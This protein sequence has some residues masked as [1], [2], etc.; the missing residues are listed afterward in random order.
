MSIIF[1][2]G[3]G[4]RRDGLCRIGCPNFP[5]DFCTDNRPEESHC[6]TRTPMD[7]PQERELADP[8]ITTLLVRGRW[9]TRGLCSVAFRR[10]PACVTGEEPVELWRFYIAQPWR[11]RR[12]ACTHAKD[13]KGCLSARQ[14]HVMAWSVGAQRASEGLLSQDGFMDV[15]SHVF[16][17]GTDA[18]TDRILV[19]PL[20]R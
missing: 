10:A 11:A 15:G 7:V 2:A 5:R 1:R 16:M 17:V 12:C 14:A 4:N 3:R 9:A 6:T 18:Q 13:G 8:D 19:G 20:R